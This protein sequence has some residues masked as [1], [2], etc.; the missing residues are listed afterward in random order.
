MIIDPPILLADHHLFIAL[1]FIACWS[2]TLPSPRLSSDLLLETCPGYFTVCFCL[3]AG[4]K[5]AVDASMCMYQ[6]L[7][8]VRQEGANLT[9][10]DGETTR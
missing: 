5:V 4:R 6:F 8:A 3:S 10:A 2:V 7:V 1:P 9:S